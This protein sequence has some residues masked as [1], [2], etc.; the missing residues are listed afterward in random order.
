M[1]QI[2]SFNFFPIN[3]TAPSFNSTADATAALYA[4][5][6]TGAR[7]WQFASGRA[8]RVASKAS[9]DYHIAFGTSDIVAA[10]TANMAVLGG[11]VETFYTNPSQSHISI[12]SS[13]FVT[14]NVTIGHG[15]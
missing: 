13:T 6:S 2:G 3:S 7:E 9:D 14:V 5:E 1:S 12:V 15:K 8:V 11:T 10:S 4:L